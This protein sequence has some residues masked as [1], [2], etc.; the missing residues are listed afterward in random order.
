MREPVTNLFSLAK[1]AIPCDV[2]VVRHFVVVT[3]PFASGEKRERWR[4]SGIEIG[5]VLGSGKQRS[6]FIPI[7]R[8]LLLQHVEQR[9]HLRFLANRRSGAARGEERKTASRQQRES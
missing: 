7:H 2:P 6:D 9:R 5:V 4:S 3:L 1:P 8:N